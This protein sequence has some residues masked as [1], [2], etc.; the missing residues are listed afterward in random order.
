ML[1]ILLE[2][3]TTARFKLPAQTAEF[4]FLLNVKPTTRLTA[5]LV[6]A[7]DLDENIVLVI[8]QLELYRFQTGPRASVKAE[9]WTAESKLWEP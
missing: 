2:L 6:V 9:R 8:F 5:V 1:A 3:Q 4:H 7:A